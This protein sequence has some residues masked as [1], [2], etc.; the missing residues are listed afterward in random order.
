MKQIELN[1]SHFHPLSFCDSNM[2]LVE[3]EGQLLRAIGAQKMGFYR[4]LFDS[5]VMDSII[6]KRLFVPTTVTDLCSE[7]FPFILRHERVKR[8]TYPNEWAPEALKSAGAMVLD[9]QMALLERGYMAV[10]IYPWNILFQQSRPVFLDLGSITRPSLHGANRAIDEFHRYYIRPLKIAAQGRWRYAVML[11]ADYYKGVTYDDFK[12]LGAG[13]LESAGYRIARPALALVRKIKAQAPAPL[14]KRMRVLL[15]GQRNES[16]EQLTESIKHKFARARTA[17]EQINL[18]DPHPWARYYEEFSQHGQSWTD[19]S[20]WNIKQHNVKTILSKVHPK[21][22][23]DMCSNRGWYSVLAESM[24]IEVIACD[25]IPD[26]MDQLFR[27]SVQQNLN[28]YPVVMDFRYPT[29][30]CGVANKWFKAATERLR[31]DMVMCLA[32][33]HHLVFSGWL[34]FDQIIEGLHAFTDKWLLIEFIPRDDEL[35]KRLLTSNYDW[36]NEKNFVAAVENRFYIRQRLPS[37]ESPRV[38][39]LCEKREV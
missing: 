10:D 1:P 34:S 11:F 33:M 3:Y 24:G 8:I 29:P 21:S 17:L 2:R 15:D 18:S 23:L 25:V 12:L 27:Q 16:V 22:L 26:V 4:N 30:A 9:L 32:T 5:G 31:C 38:L 6:E 20:D 7:N 28:I 13:G 14:K 39:M 35:V 37:Y 19:S 36:Y